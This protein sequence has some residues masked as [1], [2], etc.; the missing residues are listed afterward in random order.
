MSDVTNQL[1]HKTLTFNGQDVKANE[2]GITRIPY[3]LEETEFRILNTI[4]DG[5]ND[6]AK[7]FLFIG[8]GLLINILGKLFSFLS[9][10]NAEKKK[11]PATD[12]I[13]NWEWI[14]CAIAFSLSLI[15]LLINKYYPS[16][17]GRLKN[18]IKSFFQNSKNENEK[19]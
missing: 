3:Y 19:K 16:E 4:N 2:I 15:S 9:A 13:N 1:V 7:R 18:E 10:Q 14:A 8:F 6:W 11:T 12:D 17:K 5:F